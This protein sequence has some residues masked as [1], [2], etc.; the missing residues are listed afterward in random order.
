MSIYLEALP[1]VKMIPL[2]P[3]SI[4]ATKIVIYCK[5]VNTNS[6]KLYI[7]VEEADNSQTT[8]IS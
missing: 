1:E 8:T 5:Y 3:A 4:F 7:T 2:S 6:V